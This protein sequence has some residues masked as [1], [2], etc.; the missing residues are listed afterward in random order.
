MAATPEAVK[1]Q[2]LN[3]QMYNSN[4]FRFKVVPVDQ[5]TGAVKDLTAYDGGTVGITIGL[6]MQGAPTSTND[7]PA[8]IE[9]AD[10]SGA[11]IEVA[12]S[13]INTSSAALGGVAGIYACYLTSADSTKQML[14]ALGTLQFMPSVT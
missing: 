8:T 2:S 14:A 4:A 11:V 5:V 13:D 7:L 1:P 9:S 3:L 10:V 6:G 12:E